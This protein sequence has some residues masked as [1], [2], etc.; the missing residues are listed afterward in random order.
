MRLPPA[1]PDTTDQPR[2][3]LNTET[4]VFMETLTR[5]EKEVLERALSA[6]HLPLFPLFAVWQAFVVDRLWVWHV[7]PFVG[8]GLPGLWPVAGALLIVTMATGTV[9]THQDKFEA[10]V[11]SL[12]SN[13]IVPLLLLFYGWLFWVFAGSP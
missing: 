6:L 8:F 12:V 11:V 3:Y 2:F 1:T 7:E 9:V 13:T 5:R 4:F 10:A